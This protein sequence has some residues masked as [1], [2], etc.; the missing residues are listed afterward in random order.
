MEQQQRYTE[1][2]AKAKAFAEWLSKQKDTALRVL[3]TPEAWNKLCVELAEGPGKHQVSDSSLY[4]RGIL[5]LQDLAL[6][7]TC[8]FALIF[9]TN[10]GELVRQI[11]WN[12]DAP[13]AFDEGAEDDR[14]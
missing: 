4:W 11:H 10:E 13:F 14:G 7:G 1:A 3:V 5:L 9:E 8:F 12:E 2:P 6:K